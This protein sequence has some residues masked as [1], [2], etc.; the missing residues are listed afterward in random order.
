MVCRLCPPRGPENR[1]K[2]KSVKSRSG[3][4]LREVPESMLK[5]GQK[6][7]ISYA[8]DLLLTYLQGPRK[9]T[10]G[11]TFDLLEFSPVFGVSKRTKAT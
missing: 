9:P 6:H 8:F 5:V 4:R 2:I 10:P 7:T 3:S 1:R 11:P